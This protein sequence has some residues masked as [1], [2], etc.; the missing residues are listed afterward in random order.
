MQSQVRIQQGIF[1]ASVESGIHEFFGVPYATA[2][3]GRLRWRP[4]L[5]PPGW[6]PEPTRS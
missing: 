1:V 3:L 4:P 6:G 5:A 2:P